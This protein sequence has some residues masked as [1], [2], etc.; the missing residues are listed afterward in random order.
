MDLKNT[1]FSF[2]LPNSLTHENLQSLNSTLKRCNLSKTLKFT[3]AKVIISEENR[4][5]SRHF[6]KLGDTHCSGDADNDGKENLRLQKLEKTMISFEIDGRINGIVAPLSTQLEALIQ[7]V[8]ELSEKS[9]IRSNTG[10]R[11]PNERDRLFK[12]ATAG[13]FVVVFC[14]GM[15]FLLQPF[16]VASI[17][18]TNIFYCF[19]C[20]RI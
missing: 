19:F 10:T 20:S 16:A 13:Y 18:S 6:A 5:P 3:V 15:I 17:F 11:S 8:R 1:Y 2:L 9:S 14:L 7:S 12:A 4:T